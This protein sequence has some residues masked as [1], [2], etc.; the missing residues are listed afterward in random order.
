MASRLVRTC[1][2]LGLAAVAAVAVLH[3]QNGAVTVSVDVAA[4]RHAINQAIYG[5]AY[6][7]TAQL[8]GPERT[9]APLRRQ[10]HVAIQLA[11]E[12]RQSRPGLVLREHRRFE[13]DGRSARRRLHRQQ[14]RRQCGA[15]D[16]R[17]DHRIGRKGRARTAR[18]S[19]ASTAKSTARRTIATGSGFRTQ[20]TVSGSG[21]PIA[22]NDPNDANVANS[23]TLQQRLG[24]ASRAA[25]AARPHQAALQVLHP[26]QRAQHLALHASRRPPDRRDD[27]RDP[28][29]DDQLRG[30]DQ[31][32]RSRRARRRARGVGLERLLLQRLRPAV[33]I[34]HGWS[35]L[36]D[37]T[38]H[39]NM[40]YLPWLL[41]QLK[42]QIGSDQR[43]VLDVFTVH[44]YPQ[45]GEFGNDTSDGDAAAPQPLDA[46]AVGSELRRRDLDQ[47]QGAA[48]PAAAQ[49][50]EH[51]LLPGH[52]DR[53]HRIQLGRG[54][55]HQRRHH[56]GRHLRHLRARRARPRRAL[57]DARCGHADLQGDED[58]SQLRRQPFDVRRHQRL[59][60]STAES[61]TICR[62]SPPSGRAT[63]H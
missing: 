2:A 54:G 24:P 12:R 10:Q 5:V 18:S 14:S 26:R 13:R 53:H 44:Y 27:G 63:A 47:R 20:A 3:A 62:S 6:A 56:A 29:C 49:L 41:Q 22:G 1:A 4:S 32:R 28:R 50:G 15:D 37:R 19:P 40:D 61:Q 60:S 23:T 17:A 8:A 46:L 57:D 33:R 7:T 25:L 51:L 42:H 9:A 16:H 30:R 38:N 39:G 48:H 36:P 45:G 11:A 52:A 31:E 58:V 43:R 59:A 34:Q 21:Q 35:F 55:P